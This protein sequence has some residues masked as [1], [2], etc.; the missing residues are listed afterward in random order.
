MR[1]S[2]GALAFIVC[3]IIAFELTLYALIKVL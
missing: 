1:Y 2:D 3:L